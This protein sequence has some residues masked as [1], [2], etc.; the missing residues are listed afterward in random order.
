MRKRLRLACA[1]AVFVCAAVASASGEH[2]VMLEQV[3]VPVEQD[4]FALIARRVL[5]KAAQN[6][7]LKRALDQPALSVQLCV[8]VTFCALHEAF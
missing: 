6:A 1:F 7:N 3:E 5:E 8:F 2:Q 4:D